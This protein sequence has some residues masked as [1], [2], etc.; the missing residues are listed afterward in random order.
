[1]NK[2]MSDVYAVQNPALGA[3]IV[4]QF[5]SGYYSVNAAAVPFPLLFIVLPII[6]NK[7][8]RTV[9]KST[10]ARSGLSKVSE[11]LIQQKNNDSLYSIHS[12]AES[13]KMTSLQSICIANDTQLISVDL[14]SALV[15]PISTKKPP[16]LKSLEITQMLSSAFKIGQWCAGLPLVEICRR[17]KVRF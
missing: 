14:S 16:K 8:L 17:L 12:V 5:V 15:Y 9:I 13:L 1:M 11:K 2:A 6:Y 3:A 7:E 4:W 10:Q